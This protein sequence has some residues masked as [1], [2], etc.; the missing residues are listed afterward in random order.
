MLGGPIFSNILLRLAFIGLESFLQVSQFG[1][2]GVCVLGHVRQGTSQ[3]LTLSFDG[4]VLFP[5][6]GISPTVHQQ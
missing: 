2:T 3:I 5:Q 6:G 4:L 1:L